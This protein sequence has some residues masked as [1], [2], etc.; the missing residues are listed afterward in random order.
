MSIAPGEIAYAADVATIRLAQATATGNVALTVTP[1][2]VPGATL[3][4]VT[5][6]PTTM[7]QISATFDFQATGITPTFA[8]GV[9]NIDG[10]DVVNPQA[11]WNQSGT[12]VDARITAATSSTA[13]LT[14][15]S[16]IVKLRVFRS[17]GA[18]G[19]IR[20]NSLHTQI[21]AIVVE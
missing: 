3:T 21:S 18:D 1:A 5:T 17:G 15:G 12:A 7:A 9:I 6:R 8:V 2:D 13:T 16:H 4:V 14:P 19:Q 20:T 10:V 11:L